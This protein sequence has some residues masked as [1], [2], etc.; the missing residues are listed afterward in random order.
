[1]KK[2]GIFI[3]VI[4]ALFG[5]I[6][7]LNKANVNEVYNKPVS[8]LNPQTRALLND[9][10]YQNIILPAEL[11]SKVES[12]EGSFIYYFASDCG[13]CKQTTPLLMPI[14]EEMGINLPQFNL[15]EFDDY[16]NKMGI[17][18]TPTL[19]YYKDGKLVD[20]LEGGVAVTGGNG[21]TQE[22][23]TNFFTKYNG[24]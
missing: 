11:E 20:K 17:H 12:S 18:Y 16:F 13:F 9:P 24:Q 22:D 2:M 8:E 7:A 3:I 23:F 21:Y 4:V 15:R 1:M 14:A 6:F 10:N 19:A 5:G